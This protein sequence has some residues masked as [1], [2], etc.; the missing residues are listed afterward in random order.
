MHVIRI[1][2]S[3][4]N[5]D[6]SQLGW[7]IVRSMQDRLPFRIPAARA[8]TFR[9]IPQFAA[10]LD[11]LTAVRG[12][13]ALERAAHIAAGRFGF[14]E[15][16]EQLAPPDWNRE[17]VS[18]LWSYHLHYFDY[19][20]DLAWAARQSPGNGHLRTLSAL[21][22]SWF[23]E[24]RPGRSPGW[25]PYPI[26]VRVLNWMRVLALA[27]DILPAADR[28]ALVSATVA[29]LLVLERRLERHRRG[30][31]LQK[32]LQALAFAGLLFD[33]PDARRWRETRVA[34]HWNLVL[35]HFLPDGTHYERSSMYHS[36]ALRD[37][38]ETA[39]LVECAGGAVPSDVGTRI[40][41]ALRALGALSRPDGSLHAFNDGCAQE[42]VD[43]A[44]FAILR[45]A[46]GVRPPAAPARITV[47]PD[48]G[49]H[50]WQDPDAGDRLAIDCGR[51]GPPEQPAHV[52]CDML[53]FELDVAG[54][55]VIVDSGTAGYGGHP[56]R[57]Y[58]RSTRAHNTVQVGSREQSE[59]WGT[60]RVA[61]M[62]EPASASIDEADGRVRFA[63]ACRHAGRRCTHRRTIIGHSR[64][65]QVEDSV[66]GAGGTVLRSFLHFAPSFEHVGNLRF[67]SARSSVSVEPIGVDDAEVCAGVAVPAQGWYSPRFGVV[68]AAPV[69]ML[70]VDSNRGQMFGYRITVEAR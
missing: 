19:A 70:R 7:W 40:T 61:R 4:L 67:V 52:H 49:F 50:V 6:P 23:A 51:P 42:G 38:L 26:S 37:V 33:G 8:A 64:E 41:A 12:A 36:H 29:Q 28:D 24:A 32:N 56:L 14:L 27:G 45:R 13:A 22:T 1:A 65:W 60:F 35:R 16:E 25:E 63:G 31:H 58:C 54:E 47:L 11:E 46:A 53:S 44:V 57:E 62:A 39:A 20:V 17:Y 5:Y 9:D 55:P 59:V 18:R 48:A 66:E 43:R 21:I 30:N 10:L 34:A 3:A 15:H 69:L 68:V 2:R